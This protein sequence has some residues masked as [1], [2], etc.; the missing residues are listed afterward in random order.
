MHYPL[1]SPIQDVY[2]RSFDWVE[3]LVQIIRTVIVPSIATDVVTLDFMANT[4]FLSSTITDERSTRS[5]SH[6]RLEIGSSWRKHSIG[7]AGA[8]VCLVIAYIGSVISC[9]QPELTMLSKTV[10]SRRTSLAYVYQ[11][12]THLHTAQFGVPLKTNH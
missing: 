12:T 4:I 6:T 1:V 7:I 3:L 10:E 9:Y 5:P 11:D 2:L 8:H